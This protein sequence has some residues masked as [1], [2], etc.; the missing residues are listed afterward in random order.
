MDA[1]RQFEALKK[2]SIEQL[3]SDEKLAQLSQDWTNQSLRKRYT[4]NFTWMGRPII[5]F[6]QDIIAI[7][8]LIWRIQPD[9]I[10]E[11]GIAH[12]GSLVF[13]ASMLELLG[14]E[15]KVV[16]VDIDIRAHN[17][18]AI[19]AHP[20]FKRITMI[21]GS[22]IASDVVDQVKAECA[23]ASTVMVILDSNHSHKHVLAELE[24]YASLVKSD[25]YLIVLDTVVEF[26]DDDV[27][28]DRPWGKGDNALTAVDA[29]LATTDRFK[30]D[31]S[32]DNKLLVS[33]G[34]RGYLE[35]V[36]D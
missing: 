17:R 8:E 6:P 13:S 19:E 33:A 18:E 9:V 16:G 22:S 14:G 5:Q 1:V 11:T 27:I 25:S 2:E 30:I 28:G 12:G 36:K 29:Y 21:E 26:L 4:H 3:G 24:S 7:Q 15:R 31:H 34:P 32:M 10:V 23:G 20:M 35:C